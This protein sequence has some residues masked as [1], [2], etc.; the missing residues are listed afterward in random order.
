MYGEGISIGNDGHDIALVDGHLNSITREGIRGLSGANMQIVAELSPEKKVG[1][2]VVNKGKT[3]YWDETDKDTE[4]FKAEYQKIGRE[5]ILKEY[6][7]LT[8]ES[9]VQFRVRKDTINFLE[10][11]SGAIV[12]DTL[13]SIEEI[14]LFQSK[15]KIVWGD[16]FGEK[17]YQEAYLANM[18]GRLE[19]D[20]QKK[21]NPLLTSKE[22]KD[23]QKFENA[24][25]KYQ[26]NREKL[27]D[28]GFKADVLPDYFS[29][30]EREKI[31]RI[32]LEK[33][34]E[35]EQAIREYLKDNDL[36]VGK[37]TLLKEPGFSTKEIW[38]TIYPNDMRKQFERIT[39]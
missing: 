6:P 22:V 8:P 20:I 17:N 5:A 33:N 21:G 11:D 29:P 9:L 35:E 7:V 28:A 38:K 16:K 25:L 13:Q 24:I 37:R 15:N 34:L 1:A 31:D 12:S 19:E 26:T 32:I 39:Y 14:E 18:E 3:I 27:L 23:Y 10:T 4:K 36:L 2:L 30:D